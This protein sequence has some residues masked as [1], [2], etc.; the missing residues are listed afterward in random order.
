MSSQTTRSRN[1]FVLAPVMSDAKTDACFELC[2]EQPPEEIDLIKVVY[3]DTAVSV[4]DEWLEHTGTTPA[5]TVI[6]GVDDRA[7]SSALD[8]VDAD[9]LDGQVELLT[10]N[11]ND[12]T[13]LSMTLN[14]ALAELGKTDN[15]LYVCF[16]S[17]TALLQFVDTDSAYRFL[18]MFTGQLRKAGAVAHFHASPNAHDPQ[19]L[20]QMK[21]TFDELIEA[22]E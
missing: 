21:T 15:D 5:T 10:A 13:G 18:H 22:G 20:S 1:V 2:T 19:T 17:L 4:I 7:Q 3:R 12:L 6:V 14:N 11:P 8:E 9:E 16:D